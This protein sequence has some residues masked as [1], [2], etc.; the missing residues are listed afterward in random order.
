MVNGGMLFCLMGW[1]GV[2]QINA[3]IEKWIGESQVEFPL[4]QNVHRKMFWIMNR[5]QLTLVFYACVRHSWKMMTRK[6][7]RVTQNR[8]RGFAEVEFAVLTYFTCF[9]EWWCVLFGQHKMVRFGDTM[10]ADTFYKITT[11]IHL[12]FE[13]QCLE[14]RWPSLRRNLNSMNL[15]RLPLSTTTSPILN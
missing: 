1:V 4:L 5:N 10:T 2:G 12:L 8:R 15:Q 14:L 7:K 13:N 6:Q 11:T 3:W 9:T